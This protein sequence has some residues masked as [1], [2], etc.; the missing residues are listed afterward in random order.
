MKSN[1][2]A[3]LIGTILARKVDPHHIVLWLNEVISKRDGTKAINNIIK[4]LINTS[5][6]K[7]ELVIGIF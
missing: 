5:I 6:E 2:K 3:M 4:L 7:C 1:S